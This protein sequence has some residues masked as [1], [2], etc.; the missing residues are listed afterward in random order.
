MINFIF[1]SFLILPVETLPSP[2]IN[3]NSFEVISNSR[4]SF[5]SG[6]TAN[7]SDQVL[8]NI[9]WAMSRAPQIGS[10][11]EIYVAK[12]NNL[13]LY[14]PE[15]H[16]LVLHLSGNRR[17]NSSSAFEIGVATERY[18]EAGF[19]IQ[20]GLLS[21]TSFWDSLSNAVSCPMQSATNY[22]NNNWSPYHPIRMVNIHGFAQRRGIDTTNIAISS[23]SSLPRPVIYQNDTFEI[24]INNLG[25]DTLFL[26]TPLSLSKVSQ[27]LWAGYGVTPHMTA[28]NRRGLTVPS[29]IANYYLTRRIYL[30]N[31]YGVYRYH[32]RLPPGTNLTTADHRIELI[33]NEDRRSALRNA[34]PR[35][36]QTAP[37]YIV[38]SV[39]DTSSNYQL[40]EAGFVGIQMLLQAK[41]LNLAGS[42]T[43]PLSPNERSLIREA[44]S[45][46]SSDYPVIIFSGGERISKIEERKPKKANTFRK[47]KIYDFLGRKILE[48][49]KPLKKGIYFILYQK[50]TSCSFRKIVI[51]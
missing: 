6:F 14:N 13:Y 17:S 26:P 7:L 12:P 23:D 10:Y 49:N 3:R 46:P 48:N 16:A 8:S 15:N 18:E 34:I 43:L 22:A 28:N 25:F 44:L 37:V 29:A 45:L 5:H 32:N 40:L 33:V 35:I 50:E 9:L 39:G 47:I 27:I 20:L 24:L 36:P 30:V 2:V 38:I 4:Y 11:R 41:S 19:L 42:L 31:E 21:A 1:F 51:K